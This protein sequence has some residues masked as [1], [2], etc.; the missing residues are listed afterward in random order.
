MKRFARSH[1]CHIALVFVGVVSCAADQST[2]VAD[3]STH[4][5]SVKDFGAKGDGVTDDT[6]AIQAALNSVSTGLVTFPASSACYKSGDLMISGKTDFVLEGNHQE[7]CWA[8]TAKPG[9]FIGFQYSG[10]LTHVTLQNFR[11]TGDGV[12]GDR[13]AGVWGHSG[14]KLMNLS[15]TGNSIRNVVL[16]ISIN[17]DK[18]GTISGFSIDHN[19]IDTVLGTEPGSGYGIHHANGSGKPSNGVI[20]ENTITRAQRHSI[21]QAK[22]S[23]VLIKKNTILN[24]RQGVSEVVG[25]PRPAVQIARSTNIAFEDNVIEGAK[26]GSLQVS[27]SPGE[28]C[29]HITVNGTVITRPIGPQSA[30]TI[31]TSGPQQDGICT[32]VRFSSN[33]IS[34]EAA[35]NPVLQ[36]DS[37]KHVLVLDNTFRV[38]SGSGK[39]AVIG[40]RGYGEGTATASWTDDLTFSGNKI[41]TSGVT[42]AL[43]AVAVY[44]GAATAGIHVTF[45][46]NTFDV[47]GDKFWYEVPPTNPNLRILNP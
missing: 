23:A 22:G 18:G 34:Y 2:P 24:H 8:G 44:R 28:T 9:D 41:D 39:G 33:T 32:N 30:V 29:D 25:S 15:V 17:A 27:L 19:N 37:G 16:G 43:H 42:G 45:E 13:H 35:G 6:K 5:V 40:I 4:P 1:L 7:I 20:E 36:I 10:S 12:L 47:P 38:T 31:G 21:Y 26:D 3:P 11:L 46:R 14:A